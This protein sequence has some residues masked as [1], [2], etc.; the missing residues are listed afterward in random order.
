M[1]SYVSKA[2]H[3]PS[4]IIRRTK[5]SELQFGAEELFPT[6]ADHGR[7]Y[8]ASTVSAY[9]LVAMRRSSPQWF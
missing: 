3:I 7:R 8:L 9:V 5:L 6:L 2:S 1:Y 4:V